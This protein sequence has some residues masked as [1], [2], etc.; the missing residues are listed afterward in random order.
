[1]RH[2]LG[3][4]P[5]ATPFFLLALLA[6]PALANVR[7]YGWC[8]QGNQQVLV[9]GSSPSTTKVQRSY[10]A[11][12]ITVYYAGTLTLAP[13][14]SDN[15]ASPTPL[16]NPFTASSTG[17]WFFYASGRFDVQLSGASISPS[18]TIGDV[19]LMDIASLTDFG[20]NCNGVTDNTAAMAAAIAAAPTTLVIP[21]GICVFLSSVSVPSTITLSFA[22][23]VSP[24]TAT[25]F[26]IAGSV[27]AGDLQQIFTGL[28][29]IAFTNQQRVFSAWYPGSDCGAQVNNAYASL[30]SN[31][32]TIFLSK[33]CS[34]STP[35]LFGTFGKPCLFQGVPGFGTVLTYTGTSGVAIT[36][37][38]GGGNTGGEY[39]AAGLRDLTL[40]GPGAS[41]STTGLMWSNGVLQGCGA[42]CPGTPPPHGG[43]AYWTSYE[44]INIQNFGTGLLLGPTSWFNLFRNGSLNGNGRNVFFPS[45]WTQPPVYTGSM[46]GT[47]CCEETKFDH[48]FFSAGS[49]GTIA[50]SVW[51]GGGGM[52][53]YFEN[54]SFD[55][56]QIRIGDSGAAFG[57]KGSLVSINGSHLEDDGATGIY[58]YVQIDDSAANFV[59]MADNTFFQDSTVTGFTSLINMSGAGR[60]VIRDTHVFATENIAGFISTG[61]GF[62]SITIDELNDA[63]GSLQAL[64]TGNTTGFVRCWQGQNTS[65][66]P[67]FTRPY[68]MGFGIANCGGSAMFNVNTAAT[69]VA[70]EPLL[71]FSGNGSTVINTS[72]QPP[73]FVNSTLPVNNFFGNVK[74]YNHTGT[75]TTNTS[76]IVSD[77]GSLSG[78]A[79]TINLTAPGI[80]WANVVNG[81]ENYTSAPTVTVANCSGYTINATLNGG[82]IIALVVAAGGTCTIGTTYTMTI[83]GGGGAGGSGAVF[84]DGAAFTNSSSY[85]CS[86]TDTNPTPNAIS[87]AKVSGSQFTVS[88]TGTDGFSYTCAGN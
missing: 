29:A 75:R 61:T 77:S 18:Y 40:I 22:G 55:G 35:I 52:E 3:G 79:A 36:V 43:G 62:A 7:A 81:G 51:I 49:T 37:T 57:S 76:H 38:W 27:V 8:Q 68:A 46:T 88:G 58:S 31:G 15:L 60:L 53:V 65:T 6:L 80:V 66:N 23:Q 56:A 72:T 20:G 11:C 83:T 42:F 64:I 69:P 26:T 21:P 82:A 44:G 67:A 84:V 2:K 39:A 33:S 14:Y 47:Q 17:F 4:F 25:T 45:T 87:Y 24:A 19:K 12:T 10:P 59:R 41:T 50:N 1:M 5:L 54:C 86:V 70:D 32:A 48:V 73:L 30:A 9:P 74:I 28:G 16:A 34:F 85:N 71:N 13:I 63:G 78:G